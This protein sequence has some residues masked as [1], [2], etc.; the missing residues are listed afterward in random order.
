VSLVQRLLERHRVADL[1]VAVEKALRQRVHTRDGLVQFLPDGT[2]W[3]RTT[4]SLA[5]HPHLRLVQISQADVREH[6]RC[7]GKEYRHDREQ[8]PSVAAA[9]SQAVEV[10]DDAAGV[11]DRGGQLYEGPL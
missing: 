6:T 2:P 5:G 8:V 4:F 3:Q 1:T 7:R 10:A 11:C 9:L